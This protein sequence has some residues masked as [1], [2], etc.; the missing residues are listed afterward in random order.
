MLSPPGSA[1]L[2]TRC[3]LFPVALL[4]TAVLHWPVSSAGAQGAV[5]AAR[6]QLVGVVRDANGA[7]L[8][9][10]SVAIPGSSVRTDARGAFELFT[11]E[12]DTV[13]IAFRHV[14]YMPVDA[15]LSAR[16]KQ[17][18]TVL[19]QLDP[20]GQQLSTLK[21]T[22]SPNRRANGLRSFDERK[23]RGIGT[24]IT[25]EDIV[26]RGSSRLSDLLR[27]KR[28]VNVIRGK[29]RF[30][31]NTAGSRAASCQPDIWLDGTR[32]RGMEV[33]ELPPNTVEAMELYPYFSTVPVEFQALGSN[34]T[35]CGTIVIW[36][37]IPNGKAR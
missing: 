6:R 25:R 36:T 10:V 15:L 8:A 22:E 7:A 12:H 24:F 31:A 23:S 28:G 34:T 16:N 9:G 17:W 29:V 14:G 33:D 35:P 20:T 1:R 2:I 13:S 18:D 27:T 4:L 21:V 30:V 5:P 37:R 11:P 26:E 19:V 32:S 3:A